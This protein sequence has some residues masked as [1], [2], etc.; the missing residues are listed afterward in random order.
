TKQAGPLSMTM[1]GVEV[2]NG[3][4]MVAYCDIPPGAPYDYGAAVQAV[5]NKYSG[6]I[7]SQ[8]PVTIEGQEGRAFETEITNPKGYA[9]GRMVVINNGLYQLLVVGSTYRA[10]AADVKKFFDSFQLK[11]K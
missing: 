3:A 7:L 11:K 10:T 2:K 8:S 9:W 1:H 4:F 6:K 5:A